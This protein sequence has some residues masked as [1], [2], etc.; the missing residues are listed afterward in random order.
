M[1]DP[2]LSLAGLSYQ[3][4][5]LTTYT[6]RTKCRPQIALIWDIGIKEL[7]GK[8]HTRRG[9]GVYGST[10]TRQILPCPRA[11]ELLFAGELSAALD[12]NSK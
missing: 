9:L 4:D 3:N 7:C 10:T 1:R 11:G 8:V 2:S 5:W 6:E 12:P